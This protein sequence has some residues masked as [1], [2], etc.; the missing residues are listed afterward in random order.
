VTFSDSETIEMASRVL[1]EYMRH[2]E[3]AKK[4]ALSSSETCKRLLDLISFVQL[5][6]EGRLEEALSVSSVIHFER[7]CHSNK[8]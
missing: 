1:E 2:R 8:V 5:Y 3:I 7:N 6:E 4:L